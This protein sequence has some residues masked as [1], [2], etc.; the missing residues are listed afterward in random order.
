MPRLLQINSLVNK[1]STGR[2]VEQL[3][4]YATLQGWESYI[5]YGRKSNP[6]ES[7]LIKIG[8]DLD[9]VIHGLKSRLLDNQGLNSEK[10]TK[11]LLNRID[12]IKPDIIHLHNLHGYYINYPILFRY[13]IKKQKPIVWT[14]HDCWSF[15]GHC[16]HFA[17]INCIKWKSLCVSCPKRR[18]YP[19]SWFIDRSRKNFIQKNIIFNLLD[20]L[21]I[22]PVSRWLSEKVQESILA[23]HPKNVIYNG[24]DIN[25][26]FPRSNSIEIRRK[27]NIE[28]K[29]I[30]LGVATIWQAYKGW[31][32]YLQLSKFL[33]DKYIIVLVGVPGKQRENLPA[34]IMA[35]SRRESIDELAG[36]Y[37][38]ADVVLNLSYQETFGLTTVEGYACGTPAIVYNATASP[39]LVTPE[40]GIV[41]EP[42]NIQ[43]LA[44]AIQVITHNGKSFYSEN[45]RK[46]AVLKYD[47]DL[48]FK[49]YL[50]LYE[51]LLTSQG[52]N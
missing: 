13:L 42:G 1:G 38:A 26:F 43:E 47:K 19:S 15:T 16:T 28:N 51:K 4:Q 7:R 33:P 44:K 6:S 27:Y 29:I 9:L 45:C 22:I 14:L 20:S 10:A 50:N 48:K 2:I 40:T 5:A 17:D 11:S 23:N 34:N 24:I 12:D 49:E 21:T 46:L 8:N 39:E 37:S 32:D 30:L 25:K 52:K 41:V 18:N 35:L 36:L 3:G 31:N